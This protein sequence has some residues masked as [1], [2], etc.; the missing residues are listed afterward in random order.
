[1]IDDNNDV[2]SD[3]S[4]ENNQEQLTSDSNSQ[5]AVSSEPVVEAKSE[6]PKEPPFHLHPRFQ[7]LISERNQERERSRELERRMQELSEQFKA[8]QKAEQPKTPAIKERLKGID[9]EFADYVSRVEKVDALE[10]ELQEH[11]AFR[12]QF[13]ANAARQKT[14]QYLDK[15][16]SDN[17]VTDDR[18]EI[19]QAMLVKTA[20]ENKNLRDSDLPDVMKQIHEKLSKS[21]QTLERQTTQKY[22]ESKSEAA[23]KPTSQPKGQAV[24]SGKMEFSKDPA[25]AKR[26]LVAQI[27]K[28]TRANK[29]I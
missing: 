11:R 5:E 18:K 17:K 1:M 15:F 3:S 29:E 2:N 25:E 23:A 28:E 10:Q 26:Q 7:E 14:E 22:V 12:Q 27:L 9:P 20:N 19:Y 8:S 16:Y 13:E 4:L 21:F 6:E 24:K